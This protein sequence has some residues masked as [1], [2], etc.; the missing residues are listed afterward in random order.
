MLTNCLAACARLTITV[1]EIE[2]DIGENN[3]R[4][5]VFF[6]TLFH[7]TPPLGGFLPEYRH[8]VWYGKTRIVWLPY[9]EK[10]S[11]I[12]LFV[13]TWSTNVTDGQTDRRTDRQTPHDS[14][15]RA[16][17]ASPGNNDCEN[18]CNHFPRA[19]LVDFLLIHG[20]ILETVE[21]KWLQR[22]NWCG[23]ALSIT[24]RRFQAVVLLWH[25]M[26][27]TL[28]NLMTSVF[29]IGLGFLSYHIINIFVKRHRQS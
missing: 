12:C 22:P 15:D 28:P 23:L 29:G 4:K 7:S 17:I 13:L 21:V 27:L 8:P 11:K 16:C 26:V 9:G 2:W 18:L 5:A 6:H 19:L 10:I 14:I 1:S 24:C 20:C 3:G 25:F